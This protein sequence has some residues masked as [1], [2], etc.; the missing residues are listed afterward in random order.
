MPLQ[1]QV[2]VI[3]KN[4]FSPVELEGGLGA[5]EALEKE[6]AEVRGFYHA[7]SLSLSRE[8]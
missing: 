5:A 1:M 4:V 2:T 8:T 7:L 3:L 6:V